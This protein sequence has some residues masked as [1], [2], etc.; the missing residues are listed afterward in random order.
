M[1]LNLEY[2]DNGIY[3]ESKNLTFFD[4]KFLKEKLKSWAISVVVCIINVILRSIFYKLA[5]SE[6]YNTYTDRL[7]R[8]IKLI[9]IALF[10]NGT[11]TVFIIH[12]FI[13]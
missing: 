2:K 3:L 5:G 4:W 7:I 9:I 6:H 11:L 8:S 1:I 13:I 10:F 12:Y